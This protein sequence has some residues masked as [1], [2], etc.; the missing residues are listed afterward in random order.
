[1]EVNL[2][3]SDAEASRACPSTHPV[4]LAGEF[5]YRVGE[6]LSEALQHI[7]ILCRSDERKL[8]PHCFAWI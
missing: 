7:F 8:W 5:L 4:A 6:A 2:H 1:M 3:E